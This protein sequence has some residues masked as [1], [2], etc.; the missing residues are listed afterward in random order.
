MSLGSIQMDEENTSVRNYSGLPVKTG[1]KQ[2]KKSRS[3]QPQ[4]VSHYGPLCSVGNFAL[5]VSKTTQVKETN[6]SFCTKVIPLELEQTGLTLTSFKVKISF[7]LG[8]I[9]TAVKQPKT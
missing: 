3:N 6:L 1:F 7:G 9:C 8:S 5:T 2:F 4:S